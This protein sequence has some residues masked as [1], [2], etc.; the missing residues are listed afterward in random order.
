VNLSVPAQEDLL[1]EAGVA[2][3]VTL[4]GERG[5]R[6]ARWSVRALRVYSHN[7]ELRVDTVHTYG[8]RGECSC[9]WRGPVR[10]TF[11]LARIEAREHDAEAHP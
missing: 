4:D 9:G 10:A 11:G 1:G 8:Y 2:H 6:R 5:A 7:H 3:G